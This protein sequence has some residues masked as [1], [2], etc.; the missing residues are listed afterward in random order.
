MIDDI[1]QK[2]DLRTFDQIM[3]DISTI[4]NKCRL[5]VMTVILVLCHSLLSSDFFS[6]T[7]YS[8][9]PAP[10]S[11]SNAFSNWLLRVASQPPKPSLPTPS[12]PR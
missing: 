2:P 3:V 8:P 7:S 11:A 6:S 9:S 12:A 4:S 1:Y 5:I 10:V